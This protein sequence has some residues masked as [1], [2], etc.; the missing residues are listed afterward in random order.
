MG[1]ASKYS[2]SKNNY[3]YLYTK[4]GAFSLDGQNYVGEYHYDSGIAKT[5]PT[6]TYAPNVDTSKVLQRTY[7]NADH[8]AYDK[9]KKFNIPTLQFVNNK[10]TCFK[11]FAV[12]GT[13]IEYSPHWR[14]IVVSVSTICT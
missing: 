7:N 13:Y 11:R 4:G 6:I 10:L 9:I 14:C 3:I 5:G 12:V 2:P 8:Y 1:K